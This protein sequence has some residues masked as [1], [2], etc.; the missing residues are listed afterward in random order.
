MR[1]EITRTSAFM[2]AQPHERAE[3]SVVM[4]RAFDGSMRPHNHW[5][6]DI[7]DGNDGLIAF[8]RELDEAIILT[9]KGTWDESLPGIEIYDSYRE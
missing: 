6:I 5:V 4:I 7:P 3:Q 9:H 1:Y 2:D 8:A